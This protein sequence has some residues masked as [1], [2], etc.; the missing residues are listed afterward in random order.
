MYSCR[1]DR[2]SC[3]RGREVRSAR[4]T[5]CIPTLLV[6]IAAI[7]LLL[8]TH[9]SRA[10]EKAA[11]A[12]ATGAPG[13]DRGTKLDTVTIEA[14]RKR[15]ELEHRVSRFVFS[16]M[17]SYMYDSMPRWDKP[18]CPLVAGLPRAQGEFILAR[19]SQTAT[20]AHAPLAGEHCKANLFVVA[21]TSPDLLLSKWWAR[22]TRM[23]NDCSGLGGIKAFIH[24]KR[25]VRVWYNTMPGIQVPVPLD[26]SSIVPSLGSTFSC[27]TG[28][29]AGSRL[30]QG[31]LAFSQALVVIDMRQVQ[32]LT[33]GQLADYVS[34]VG[35]AQIQPD[36]HP[37]AGPSILKLFED[38]KQRPEELS[39]WD[40]ALLY[41]LYHTEQ[42]NTLQASLMERSM[43]SQIA[44]PR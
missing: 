17:V 34:M 27:L 43:V 16:V 23:Y 24:S 35:L 29:A 37:V 12:A 6:A 32:D 44:T 9:P 42:S 22:D 1:R 41:A 40:R 3:A 30:T 39:E 14:A 25:S 2:H 5:R 13:S 18:I 11:D 38:E 33:I 20:A 8:H 28:G 31:V 26:V 19:I 7:F 10:A 36:T 15:R 21:T 4:R